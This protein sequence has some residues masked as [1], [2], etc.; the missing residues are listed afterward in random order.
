MQ[1]RLTRSRVPALLLAAGLSGITA[2]SL[3]ATSRRLPTPPAPESRL[4]ADSDRSSRSYDSRDLRNLVE[5]LE[6]SPPADIR[7]GRISR[8]FTDPAVI[9]T[10]GQMHHIDWSRVREDRSI[11][12]NLPN[13]DDR[14]AD[15]R[16]REV[17]RPNADVQIES[18]E[19]R[20]IDPRTVVVMYTAVFPSGDGLTR[21]PVVAT[22]IRE[23]GS[24]RW[25][26]ATY[27]AE[28]AAIPG[29]VDV[30]DTNRDRL[31]AR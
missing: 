19:T 2:L 21:Q 26:V 9:V 15:P 1:H 18:F 31:P 24:S 28:N 4:Q 8:F 12:R 6:S 11:D 3:A 10:N 22:V 7:T 13:G 14:N 30:E 17:D 20:R 16:D 23:T 27:T 29:G 25:R 5:D